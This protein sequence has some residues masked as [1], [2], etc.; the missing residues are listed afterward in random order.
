MNTFIKYLRVIDGIWPHA[1]IYWEVGEPTRT[2]VKLHI[3]GTHW[4]P[5]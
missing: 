1:I 3:Y 2:Q 5:E 4:G